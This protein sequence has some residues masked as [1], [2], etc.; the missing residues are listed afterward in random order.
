LSN[1]DQ[2]LI[3][4]RFDIQVE[5]FEGQ[6]YG[7]SKDNI[8]IA[9]MPLV[10]I[11]QEI[12][13]VGKRAFFRAISHDLIPNAEQLTNLDAVEELLFIGYPNG[14]FDSRNL[15]PIV[16]RGTTATPLQ[17]D[18]EG[19]PVFLMDASVFPGS[20]GS[21]VL[22]ANSGGYTSKGNFV[23]GTRAHFLGIVASV[24]IR[25]ELGKIDFVS[26]PTAQVPIFR[27]QQMLDL[28]IVYKSSA[29]L[30]V[31]VEFLKRNKAI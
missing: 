22:I 21:P 10:P 4:Q 26:I 8:D 16:R 23:V 19:E 28:G 1:G 31:V 15:I 18:Y 11:L 12:E 29:V 6:W 13:R 9:I 20:S 2:P 17:I 7:H 3:G 30:D 5:N 27:T 24:A 14:I 25:E